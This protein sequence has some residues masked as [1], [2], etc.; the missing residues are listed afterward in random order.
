M[1]TP[2]L[3]VAAQ[4]R[5][6]TARRRHEN[7]VRMLLERGRVLGFGLVLITANYQLIRICQWTKLTEDQPWMAT[8]PYSSRCTFNT[9]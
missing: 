4:H 5:L 7:L 6:P 1:S 8:L 2:I 9:T 3:D